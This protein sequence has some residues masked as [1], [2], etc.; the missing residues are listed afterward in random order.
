MMSTEGGNE[1]KMAN[2]GSPG[3]GC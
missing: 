3:K 2:P 1:G